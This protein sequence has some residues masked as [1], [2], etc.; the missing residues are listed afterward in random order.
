MQ[1][2]LLTDIYIYPIKSLGGIRLNQAAIEERGLKYDRRWMLVDQNGLF[3]SQ[4]KHSK[5]A[6]LQVDISDEQLT[7]TDKV[8]RETNISF[9]LFQ[10]T[11]KLM[12]VAIWDSAARGVE[13]SDE[14]SNWFSIYLDFEVKLVRLP[15][16]ERIL[17]DTKYANN[18]EITSFSDGYPCL[19]IGQSS[20]DMLN[21]K[22]SAPILMNRFR[23]NF[24][25]S[26]GEAHIEDCFSTFRL[27]NILFSAVK[28]CARCVMTT[29]NQETGIKGQEPL[30][31]LASYRS[32]EKKI[33]FGQNLIH[34]GNGIIKTGSELIVEQWKQ[35]PL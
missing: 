33:M 12:D 23:P 32:V 30:K 34:K 22:L 15:E 10:D 26:G 31:T 17:V 20:M 3:V 6:M 21:Q 16:Q 24:V 19:I 14:V 9:A 27:G 7:V 11:G 29:I 35:L 1:E 8:D 5:L 4:R 28:P 18:G 25:F 13:V 2:L